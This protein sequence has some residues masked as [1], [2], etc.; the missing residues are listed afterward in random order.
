MPKWLIGQNPRQ[1]LIL[2]PDDERDGCAQAPKAV[3]IEATQIEATPLAP[4]LYGLARPRSW[5]VP[6]VGEP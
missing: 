3:P 2:H 1:F 4:R 5:L 6:T